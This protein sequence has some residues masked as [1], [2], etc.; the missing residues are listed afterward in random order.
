MHQF[1]LKSFICTTLSVLY[2]SLPVLAS[3]S[4]NIQIAERHVFVLHSGPDV[5]W[6][7]YMFGVNNM[8]SEATLFSDRINLPSGITDFAPQEGLSNE[9]LKASPEGGLV[10]EKEFPPGVTLIAIGFKLPAQLGKASLQ[11]KFH[12]DIS[13]MSI[14]TKDDSLN[15]E[16]VGVPMQLGDNTIMSN[17]TYRT[18]KSSQKIAKGQQLEV[19]VSNIAG[20][21]NFWLV[22][23]IFAALLLL[24]A[25]IFTLKTKESIEVAEL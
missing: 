8:G 20:R 12:Y 5:L 10:F 24:L 15:L 16:F 3:E 19:A 11:L 9:E 13:E 4:E 14:L 1:I 25:S 7:T 2:F 23:S 18:F 21:A 6:G 22:G 17:E